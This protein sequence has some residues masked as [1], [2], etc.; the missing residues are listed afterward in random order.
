MNS[1]SIFFIYN[2]SL[3]P[4]LSVLICVCLKKAAPLNVFLNKL[5]SRKKP[6]KVGMVQKFKNS[7]VFKELK[8]LWF[9]MITRNFPYAFHTG[10]H[11]IVRLKRRPFS[12]PT[13]GTSIPVGKIWRPC[14]AKM[15]PRR[16]ADRKFSSSSDILTCNH[17][18]HQPKE[19]RTS[20]KRG[21]WNRGVQFRS[22]KL[23]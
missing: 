5:C 17:H 1:T 3:R 4:H 20:N 11:R 15:G 22:T 21:K 16:P 2:V 14:N 19:N 10:C 13:L 6:T 7:P 23:I 9:K 8:E 18:L 12:W